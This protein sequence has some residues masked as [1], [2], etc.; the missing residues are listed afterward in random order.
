MERAKIMVPKTDWDATAHLQYEP[1]GTPRGTTPPHGSD[2]MEFASLREA[3]H[4]AMTNEAPAG[5]H[6]VIRTASGE[7]I[8]PSQLEELWASLQGP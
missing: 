7:V 8:E 3:I 5:M 2:V 6:A 4:W 1:M